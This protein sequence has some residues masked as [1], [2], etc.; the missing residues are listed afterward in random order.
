MSASDLWEDMQTLNTLYQELCW[1]NDEELEFVPD[2]E[3]NRI[4]IQLKYPNR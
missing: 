2:F 3:N 4:I 1:A